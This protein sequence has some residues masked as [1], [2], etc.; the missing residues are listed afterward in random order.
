[1]TM[2]TQA[3]T[4]W[5]TRPADERFTTLTALS[6]HF[7]GLK[8]DSRQATVS[9]RALSF[10]PDPTDEM[11]GLQVLI[12]DNP[13]GP[14]TATHWSF[15]QL[16]QLGKAP[17]HYLRTLPAPLA[18]DNLNYGLRFARD[19]EDVGTLTTL[20]A[21]RAA[22]GAGYGRIW[23]ADL[24]A[25]LVRMFGDGQSGQFRIPGEFG[26]PVPVTPENTT[27]YGSD[28]DMFVFLVDEKN[29]IEIANRRN[30]EPGS[31]ARGFFVWN[32]EVGS[33]SI[34][35]AFFLF[36]FVCK[37]RCVWGVEQ[38]KEIRL[39]HTSGAPDRWLEQIQPVLVEYSNASAK[40]VV[41]AIEAARAKKIDDVKEFLAKRFT[42]GQVAD[43]Q[44]AHVRDE[45]RPIETVYDAVNGVT[46]LA[47]TI[48]YQ[49][50]RV[51]LERKGG[52]LMKLAA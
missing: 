37:N 34:G 29:R 51:A 3:S 27:L 42:K 19:V 24:S 2:L 39:R 10:Q 48:K 21:L 35:A 32:S 26:K 41:E 23:N 17:A 45:G 33:M 8:Q 52:E 7:N 13:N 38:F 28:R 46:A 15:G 30:G 20:K 25:T 1:M 18:A 5:A 47:R 44:Q 40:P 6:D 9:S 36:D 22:T 11:K 12:R 31:L 43:I 50:E 49:D 4:Q 14:F 16:A